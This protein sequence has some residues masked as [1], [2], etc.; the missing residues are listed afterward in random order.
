MIYLPA[1]SAPDEIIQPSRFRH[2]EIREC[3]EGL[4]LAR[5]QSI[6]ASRGTKRRK[7]SGEEVEMLPLLTQ[8][9]LETMQVEPSGDEDVVVFEELFL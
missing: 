6:H 8:A 4:N 5:G 7:I 3:V 1:E 2:Q 9:I